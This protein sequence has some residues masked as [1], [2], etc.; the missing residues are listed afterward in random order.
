MTVSLLSSSRKISNMAFSLNFYQKEAV[1][2]NFCAAVY[3]L[4]FTDSDGKTISDVPRI[5]ADKTEENAEGR[6]FRVNFNLKPLKYS[7]DETYYL[8]IADSDGLPICREEFL[9]DIALAV[10]EFDFFG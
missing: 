5:L 7:N 3:P 9:I 4:Y 8:V 10:D 1:A 6:I 2:A